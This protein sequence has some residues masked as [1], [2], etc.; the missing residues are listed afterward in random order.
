MSRK[1]IDYKV[2]N[3]KITSIDG[4]EVAGSGGGSGGG[5]AITKFEEKLKTSG[6][7]NLSWYT[8]DGHNRPEPNTSYNIGDC[9]VLDYS[10]TFGSETLDENQIIVPESVTIVPEKFIS[11]LTLGD[12]VLA[13]SGFNGYPNYTTSD[14]KTFELKAFCY[15]YFTVIKAGTTG[16]SISLP[17]APKTYIKYAKETLGKPQTN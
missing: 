3:G 7:S 12:V 9:F 11:S 16:T 5:I 14:N 8:Y 4:Y 15:M 1:M 2:E 13:L 17:R 10:A 6:I